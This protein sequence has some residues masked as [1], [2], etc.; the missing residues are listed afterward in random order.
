M[1]GPA[2]SR[3]EFA[4]TRDVCIYDLMILSYDNKYNLGI[5][6]ELV[7]YFKKYCGCFSDKYFFLKYFLKLALPERKISLR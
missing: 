3:L 1:N 7:T 6:W 4:Y 5:K 2:Q